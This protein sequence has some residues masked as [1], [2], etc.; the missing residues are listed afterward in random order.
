MKKRPSS[1]SQRATCEKA[2]GQLRRC[3]NISTDTIRSKRSAVSKTLKSQVCT[4]T[5]RSPRSAAS[6][7]MY[8]RWECELEMAVIMLAG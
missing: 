6:A 4:R 8:R 3:S 1:A 2:R 5:L 7:S